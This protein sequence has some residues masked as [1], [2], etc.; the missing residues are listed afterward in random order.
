MELEGSLKAFSLPEVLQFLSM[1]KMSG[2]LHLSRGAHSIALTIKLGRIVNSS[3]LSRNLRLGEMLIQRGLLK[4]R[5]L[6]EILSLQKTIENDKRL[7]ELLLER[8]LI[9]NEDL[10]ETIRLQLEEEVWDLF[11]WEDGHF[12]FENLPEQEISHVAVHIDIEPLLLE[13]SR[14]Q[15]E[16]SKIRNS[17]PDDTVVF[18]VLALPRDFQRTLKLSLAEWKVLSTLNGHLSVAAVVH[19]CALGRFE[20][21]HILNSFLASELIEARSKTSAK[22]SPPEP[23]ALSAEA[24]S[25]AEELM[26]SVPQESGPRRLGGLFGGRPKVSERP[27]TASSPLTFLSPAS[28]LAAVITGFTQ[29]AVQ[30]KDFAAKPEEERLLETFWMELLMEHPR[31]D[32]LRCVGN[33]ADPTILESYIETTEFFPVVQECHEEIVE[34]LG[35]LLRMV[36]RISAQRLG[37]RMAQKMLQSLVEAAG[38]RVTLRYGNPFDLAARCSRILGQAA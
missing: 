34:A 3:T 22:E 27:E 30:Q 17:I 28:L 8:D 11:S 9:K 7:G 5:D 31:A 2:Y 19:R 26:Q 35:K 10:R 6:E 14:R 36:Y 1:G 24:Q 38:A 25:R 33:V 12:K 16:W 21:C 15:D 37:E 4:R 32:L 29:Q 23:R 18:R 20:T 13:G